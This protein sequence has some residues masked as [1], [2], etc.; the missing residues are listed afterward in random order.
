MSQW[1]TCGPL[2]C[3]ACCEEASA[4]RARV[5]E[6]EAQVKTVTEERD[7]FKALHEGACGQLLKVAEERDAEKSRAQRFVEM[8]RDHGFDAYLL[9]KLN[10]ER[11]AQ[12]R[13]CG[14]AVTELTATHKALDA[15][16]RE[17]DRLREYARHFD[18]CDSIDTTKPCSCGLVAARY[19][20]R[21]PKCVWPVG[22]AGDTHCHTVALAA[23][24]EEKPSRETT[25]DE[26]FSKQGG[27]CAWNDD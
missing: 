22:H 11:D 9:A 3:A 18:F 12:R 13:N 20:E 14:H 15:T 27:Q 2:G 19:C 23:A 5:A 6:L 26:D 16:R 10:E 1:H 21:D 7:T 4:L 25:E 17:A 24:S 8:Y